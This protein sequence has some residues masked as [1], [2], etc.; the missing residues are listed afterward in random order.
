MGSAQAS[1]STLQLTLSERDRSRPPPP[2]R[3]V[4]SL[5]E[6]RAEGRQETHPADAAFV[7]WRDISLRLRGAAR[8]DGFAGRCGLRSAPEG[9]ARG[10]G[11]LLGRE[12]VCVIPVPSQK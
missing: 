10:P 12:V 4:W 5:V 9:A 7:G 2:F 1:L 3:R 8:F 6:D 11:G